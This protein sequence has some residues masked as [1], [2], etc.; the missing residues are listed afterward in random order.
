MTATTL[1]ALAPSPNQHPI[2][3]LASVVHRPSRLYVTGR[4][5]D[6][7]A[8]WSVV[9][10]VLQEE[11]DHSAHLTDEMRGWVDIERLHNAY[12]DIANVVSL[13]TLKKYA[14]T[15]MQHV[16]AMFTAATGEHLIER[17]PLG[18]RI[19][20]NVHVEKPTDTRSADPTGS[21]N[22]EK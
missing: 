21:T 12:T 17:S 22:P 3:Q 14:H 8:A 2:L 10:F 1:P 18:Y 15:T 16:N 4:S 20:R 19:V 11:H 13:R 5:H 6:L 9:L 7:K